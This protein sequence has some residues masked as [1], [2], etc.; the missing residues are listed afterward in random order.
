MKGNPS[1]WQFGKKRETSEIWV[2]WH[3]RCMNMRTCEYNIFLEITCEYI[4]MWM[5][6]RMILSYGMTCEMHKMW[7]NR[8][9]LDNIAMHEHMNYEHIG[10]FYML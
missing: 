5:Y 7:A 1:V 6:E 2:R 3:M 8:S 4:N 10:L 9:I